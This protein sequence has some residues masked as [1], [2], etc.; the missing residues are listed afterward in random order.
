[1]TKSAETTT[2]DKSL[3]NGSINDGWEFRDPSPFF[4]DAS[5]LNSCSVDISFDFRLVL[6]PFDMRV[7]CF[8][9]C[10]GN[11]FLASG[12]H[13]NVSKHLILNPSVAFDRVSLPVP[14]DDSLPQYKVDKTFADRRYKVS[15]ARTY[16]YLNESTCERNMEIFI[17]C[18]EA[19]SGKYSII[20]VGKRLFFL[21]FLVD[22]FV[23][24]I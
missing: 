21:F 10:V 4:A 1:M 11:V 12:N 22:F 2:G 14:V 23:L 8:F 24:P 7:D 17:K 20:L 3:A 6:N 19:V 16:F 15:S 9:W 5:Y 13:Y 18:L